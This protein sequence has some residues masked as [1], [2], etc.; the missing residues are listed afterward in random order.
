MQKPADYIIIFAKAFVRR[1]HLQKETI[2]K[3]KQSKKVKGREAS[4]TMRNGI[5]N[6]IIIL[7]RKCVP[8]QKYCARMR[9]YLF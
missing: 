2:Q 6:M 5:R 8:D 3:K 4:E 9:T 7:E 1:S